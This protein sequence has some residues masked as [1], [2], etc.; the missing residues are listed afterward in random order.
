MPTLALS[1]RTDPDDMA[2][3]T[4]I[5]PAMIHRLMVVA[6]NDDFDGCD[7]V[8]RVWIHGLARPVPW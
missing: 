7:P 1:I 5:A 6:P 2:D 3:P 8:V 4:I